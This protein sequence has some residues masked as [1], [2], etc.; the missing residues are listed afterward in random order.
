MAEIKVERKGL[1]WWAWL[2]MALIAIALIWWVVAETGDD[3]DDLAAPDVTIVD[4]VPA[5]V[6]PMEPAAGGE[7]GAVTDIDTLLD[8]E[9]PAALVGRQVRLE[10]VQVLE[11]VGDA[12]FWVGRGGDD[13]AFVILDEQIPS[14]PPE[15]EGR[16]N[17]NAGQ[18]VDITGS[19][20]AGGDL[21]GGD[22][23]DKGDRNAVDGR[24]IYIW[25]Q[26]ATVA[27]RP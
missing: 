2:I 1:P 20:R 7:A 24:P 17:V 25:A 10:G 3:G 8:A 16:V 4:T 12:T 19:V 22:V 14:P 9:D 26:S 21:P 11:M 15:V 6:M 18:T 5:P 23:L 13:R 27:T